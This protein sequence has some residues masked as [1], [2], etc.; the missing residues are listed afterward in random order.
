MKKR[1]GGTTSKRGE[2]KKRGKNPHL[3]STKRKYMILGG[4]RESTI[5]RERKKGLYSWK[6][7]SLQ[8]KGRAIALI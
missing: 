4:R 3:L 1:E 8:K 2:K 7:G 5:L 6:I